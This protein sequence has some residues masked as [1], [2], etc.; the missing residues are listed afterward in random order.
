M[1]SDIAPLADRICAATTAE[2]IP[3]LE[4]AVAAASDTTDFAAELT[5]YDPSVEG[6]FV[7]ASG[8]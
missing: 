7:I 6:S 8:T 2:R 4:A 5:A 3:Q 1:L